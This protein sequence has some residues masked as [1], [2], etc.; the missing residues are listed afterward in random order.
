[1]AENK[2]LLIDGNSLLFRAFYALP[3]LH[4][5]EG[6]YT[7][8]VYGFLTMF[9]RVMAEQQPS[10]VLVAFD[11]D[12]KTFRN[13]LYIDYKANRGATPEELTGQFQ[14]LR[15]LLAAMNVEYLEIQ[16]FE[17]DDIIGTLSKQAEEAGLN[18]IILT[19]DG[20]ALQLVSEKVNVL[21]TKKGISEMEKYDPAKVKE[22]WEVEPEKM[23]EIKALMGD[24]SDNIPGVPGIGPKTAVKLIKEFASLENLYEHLDQ[25][26]GKKVLERL[27]EHRDLAFVSRQLATI[28]REVEDDYNFE[29]YQ[30]KEAHQEDLLAIYRRLEFNNFHN[31]LQ[32]DMAMSPEPEA[33]V[34][35]PV[36]HQLE[37]REDVDGFL[38][39]LSKDRE[40]A[41]YLEVD[42][43]HPMWAKISGVFCEYEQEVYW[44]DVAGELNSR[45]EW[46]RPLFESGEYKKYLHNAKFAQVIL[47][48]HGIKLCG[49]A[50]DTM[51]LAYVNDP[52]FDGW[53]LDACIAKFLNISI[54][55]NKPPMLVAVLRELYARLLEQSTPELQELLTRVE[56]PLSEVLA[57]MEFCGVKVDCPT[58]AAISGELA[59]GIAGCENR[60]F[61][62]AGDSF[63][64]NSPKQLGKVLF[65]DLG[66]RIVKKSK[67]GYATGA[68]ILEELYEDHEI[69]PY[70]LNYRQLTKLKSTYVDALQNLI[71]PET[72][73][74]HTI[75]KQAQTATG[76]LSSVEPNLQNIPIRM[77]EGRR[78][79]KAFTA[80]NEDWLIVSADYSQIDLRSLAHI[81]GDQTLIDTF[82]KG[83]DIHTRTASEIFHVPMEWVDSDFRHR[84]KAVN[85][86]IIY[87]ISD[88]GLA[89]DTGVSRKEA[90]KYID[91]YLDSYPGVKQYMEDI[92]QFGKE[93]GYVETVLK[94]RRYLPDLNARNKMVQSF[95]RRMALNTPVQGTSADIIKLAMIKVFD[96]L[97]KRQLQARLLLQ[98]HD[99][100][101]LEVPER[102]VDEVAALLQDSMEHAF[103]LKVPLEVS[104]KAGPNWYDM[105]ALQRREG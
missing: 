88:F 77:E 37:S 36:L 69:I 7:N 80:R 6:V 90:R 104:L 48:R 45:L 98:V 46:L 70:I 65:E 32:V 73:R 53:E 83:I 42:Y 102:E 38:Q 9:R 1:M 14:L 60:I 72:G 86:G 51:L 34:A 19:G 23:I 71:H 39:Q 78:I 58:L 95:A 43:H 94:R 3:L 41:I 52:A 49:V 93:N 81:S 30:V 4:T 29:D 84:A 68:E 12:R 91:N 97:E 76:R 105:K 96:Q 24:S 18:T 40:L 99:D 101:V 55:Q 16:G 67:T 66:L 103:T 2:F 21:M 5:S 63:N 11:K 92:V 28:N 22:K 75:F 26:G 47:L 10:H 57:H 33:S 87:G 64:I 89:R 61:D 85:F 13:D 59:E 56:M 27:Q 74:V 25:V 31:A 54:A 100:L 20:D 17:A 8:G 44:L 82:K 79:R 15:D 35:A 62:L 50:G